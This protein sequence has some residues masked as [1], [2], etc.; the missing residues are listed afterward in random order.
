MKVC[1]IQ[2][3][4]STDYE[5]S[6]ENFRIQLE[7]LAQCD[8]SMDLIV[9]PESCDIPAL[10]KGKE[11][12]LASVEKNNGVMIAKAKETAI[13][14]NAVVFFN[15]RSRSNKGL[16]KAILERQPKAL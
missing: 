5:K 2:P 1:I 9:L 12:R 7:L 13:R 3:P 14:C 11:R 4:Y 15:A 16:I 8:D 6:D 10:A